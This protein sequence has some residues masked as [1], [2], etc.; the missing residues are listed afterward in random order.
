MTAP[1]APDDWHDR[2]PGELLPRLRAAG[3]PVDMRAQTLV[4]AWLARVAAEAPADGPQ[5]ARGVLKAL[6]A[7]TPGEQEVFDEVFDEWWA[8]GKRGSERPQPE[9][10]SVPAPGG[11][12]GSPGVGPRWLR[13]GPWLQRLTWAVTVSLVLLAGAIWVLQRTSQEAEMAVA[14][15]TGGLEIATGPR[16]P[17]PDAT[18]VSFS[19]PSGEKQHNPSG[20]LSD[21]AHWLL[22]KLIDPPARL[23][24]LHPLAYAIL[25][26]LLAALPYL[27]RRERQQELARITTPRSDLREQEVYAGR[28]RA[29]GGAQRAALR[30]AARALRRQQAMEGRWLDLP[31]TVQ[32]SVRAAGRF[33]PVLR[34]RQAMRSYLV[35]IDR[36]RA[37]EARSQLAWE[38]ASALAA[39]GV[40]LEVWEFD[41]DPRWLR[42]FRRRAVQGSA[43]EALMPAASSHVPL[44]A[45]ASRCSGMGLLL[46][47]D[48]AGLLDLRDGRLLPWVRAGFDAWP[49]RALLTPLPIDHW[50]DEERCLA[51]AE[52][53]GF[54]VAPALT[55]ALPMVAQW[56][57]GQVPQLPFVPGAPGRLPDELM[58]PALR[59]LGDVPVDPAEQESMIGDLRR[60]LGP[61][62]FGWLAASAAYPALSAELTAYLADALDRLDGV[63]GRSAAADPDDAPLREMQAL[64]LAQL[65]WFRQGRMPDWWRLT[66][67]EALP[68]KAL[69]AV[70]RALEALLQA[71]GPAHG[72]VSL[73]SIASAEP[74]QAWQRWRRRQRSR[75]LAATEAPGSPLRDV[76]YLGVLD[77][78]IDRRLRLRARWGNGAGPLTANPLRWVAAG[79]LL[80]SAPL[81]PLRIDRAQRRLRWPGFA[82]ASVRA[83]LRT[84]LRPS[85]AALTDPAMGAAWRVFFLL[86]VV[87]FVAGAVLPYSGMTRMTDLIAG[88]PARDTRVATTPRPVPPA[89]TRF[90]DCPDDSCP[91]MVV[92]PA[93]H[94]LMGSPKGEPGRQ[95]P[96]DDD[97]SPQHEVTLPQP[98]AVMETEVTVALYRRFSKDMG[99]KPGGN[100]KSW[101]TANGIWEAVAGVDWR[102]PF[103]AYGFEQGDEHPVVCV[104]WNDAQAFARWMSKRTGQPY[105]LLSEAE[106]EYAARA[107]R[108][109]RFFFGTDI[110]D[111]CRYGNVA[112]QRAR[113]DIAAAGNWT[114]APCDD[115]FAFTAPVAS[116]LPNAFGLYD[117]LG[118]ALEWVQDCYRTYP[119]RD[120]GPEPHEAA[121]CDSRVLRGGAWDGDPAGA[122]LA[123]R[124]GDVPSTSDGIVGFRLARML[125]PGS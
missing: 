102:N 41:R 73:G 68:P 25:L 82:A 101:S 118:N 54:F 74:T 119:A 45:L 107:G 60:A 7:K 15:V 29:P 44:A 2:V 86:A 93:G 26:V 58:G 106:W 47:G 109:T 65:P 124:F 31:A 123:H 116:Y 6:L 104:D 78:S 22:A 114:F 113:R 89:G 39:E 4:L 84:L 85:A 1:V 38:R 46:F 37:G 62:A 76:I 80:L 59:W 57:A 21:F 122:R 53:G 52:R 91:W 117:M 17:R 115:G 121:K 56:W 3:V 49:Q 125:P 100:C 51:D 66:L 92:I 90:R 19:A 50:G 67:L 108:G 69:V 12:A 14:L 10:S 95:E 71:E 11:A 64:A 111:F 30:L 23:F 79:M 81:T 18:E 40:P 27:V 110:A 42:P 48:G 32:A 105:R 120:D 99:R 98:L 75:G 61:R 112:D 5:A 55:L 87:W 24:G 103:K 70:R 13:W 97:E 96:R 63:V 36:P 8:G 88:R 94:F 33:D 77:G 20:G 72:D 35:L 43:G 9:E 34:S 83:R 16:A 28:R